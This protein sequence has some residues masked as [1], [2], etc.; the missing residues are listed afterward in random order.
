VTRPEPEDTHWLARPE[1]IRLLWR[2]GSVVLGL[3]VLADFLVPGYSS[4]TIDGTFGFYAWYGFAT[5]VAM[6]FAAKALGLV[7]KRKDTYYDD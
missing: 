4:F 7:V 2:G 5:C 3:L 6:V 1:T